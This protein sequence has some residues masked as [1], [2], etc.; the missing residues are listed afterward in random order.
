MLGHGV[1]PI[2]TELAGSKET[3]SGFNLYSLNNIS[4]ELDQDKIRKYVESC[5][6]SERKNHWIKY[7]YNMSKFNIDCVYISYH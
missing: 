3:L 4:H 5:D 1:K 2:A 6:W 7:I